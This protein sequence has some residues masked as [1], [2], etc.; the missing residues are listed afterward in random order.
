[1]KASIVGAGF[2]GMELARQL[3]LAGHDS[4]LMD[5]LPVK[6]IPFSFLHFDVLQEKLSLPKGT[7][8]VYYLAQSPYYREF[9]KHAGHLFGVNMLGA[10]KTA[11]AAA[12]MGC[13]FFFYA[14]T[15][16][17]YTPSF[18]ALSENDPAESQAAYA[19]SKRMAER[20]LALFS[21]TM[22]VC[23]GRIFGVFGPGQKQMLP[24]LV[25]Q[26]LAE[27]TP[28]QLAP[29][30]ECGHDGG[31][32][33]SFM[34]NSD[35]GNI[36]VQLAERALNGES[37]PPILNL[38]GPESVSL[39]RLAEEMGKAMGIAPC[40]DQVPTHRNFDLVADISLLRK[41]VDVRFTPLHK[42]VLL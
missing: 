28:I 4:V 14:S 35:L 13:R 36:L 16:N 31:L 24:A 18:N 38:G 34:F 32:H 23:A 19:L 15:G 39:K 29:H 17:V 2:V 20:A 1:M 21:G 42:A 25:R 7:D 5:P 22:T 11:E 33:V 37:L 9:P 6:E 12:E 26:R 3:A 10:I 41:T 40:F 30:P 27:N 8:A